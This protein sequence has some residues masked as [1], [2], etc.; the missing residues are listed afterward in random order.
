MAQCS[1]VTAL[2][3]SGLAGSLAV[4]LAALICLGGGRQAG[5]VEL[6]VGELAERDSALCPDTPGGTPLLLVVSGG[7]EAG[8]G[9]LFERGLRAIERANG[10][11]F[12]CGVQFDSDGG[13]LYEAMLIGRAIRGRQLATR[14]KSRD[15][16]FSACVFAFI[17]GVVRLPEGMMGIHSF[18]APELLGSGNYALADT[19]YNQTSQV[20]AAYLME[21]RV[22]Q[23]LLDRMMRIQHSEIE[24]LRPQDLKSLGVSGVDPVYLQT[25]AQDGGQPQ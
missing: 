24:I 12:V 7:F 23:L 3:R 11:I 4:A 2:R 1:C 13:D 19:T 25:R 9:A 8:D 5:A 22:S 18:Y 15:H 20:V 16:C 10:E 14:V 21:M 17:G 6:R